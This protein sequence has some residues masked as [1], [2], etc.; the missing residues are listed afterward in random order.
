M[1]FSVTAAVG[2]SAEGSNSPGSKERTQT[3][4]PKS[5]SKHS[6][7]PD[8]IPSEAERKSVRCHYRW[9]ISCAKRCW[10][11]SRH[12]RVNDPWFP[13]YSLP[14]SRFLSAMITG[15]R[16]RIT[17]PNYSTR[18]SSKTAVVD[19]SASCVESKEWTTQK[20]LVKAKTN[21]TI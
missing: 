10:P 19:N 5:K 11:K 3:T 14:S 15:A 8:T 16:W 13:F 6:Y 1:W 18:I 21:M 7:C 4:I 9:W 17:F 20:G 12:R 2:W